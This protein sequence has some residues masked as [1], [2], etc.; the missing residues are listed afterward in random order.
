VIPESDD[1]NMLSGYVLNI[2]YQG[3]FEGPWNTFKKMRLSHRQ[4]QMLRDGKVD[5][6]QLSGFGPDAPLIPFALFIGD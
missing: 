1:A 6:T 2:P 5:H 4:T 3:I